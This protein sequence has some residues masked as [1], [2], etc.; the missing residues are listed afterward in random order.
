M[1]SL[2]LPIPELQGGMAQEEVIAK[3]SFGYSIQSEN[4]AL[5]IGIQ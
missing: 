2:Q 1:P 3:N 4:K 5:E